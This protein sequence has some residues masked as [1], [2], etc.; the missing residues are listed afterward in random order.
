VIAFE[1][2]GMALYNFILIAE[3]ENEHFARRLSQNESVDQDIMDYTSSL[4]AQSPVS[5]GTPTGSGFSNKSGGSGT[6]RKISG[7]RRPRFLEN[8]DEGGHGN[9]GLFIS[10]RASSFRGLNI[11]DLNWILCLFHLFFIQ[12]IIHVYFTY[13][14]AFIETFH[15]LFC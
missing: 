2:A 5:P 15:C 13:E 12:Q 8:I 14:A 4:E 10:F 6:R 9:R 1:I 3:L 11:D 7:E